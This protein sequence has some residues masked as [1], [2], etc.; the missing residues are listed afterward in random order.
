M[1]FSHIYRDTRL[2]TGQIREPNSHQLWHDEPQK[3]RQIFP[4]TVGSSVLI[5]KLGQDFVEKR[6]R[7]RVFWTPCPHT[8]SDRHE[9]WWSQRQHGARTKSWISSKSLH[10]WQKYRLYSLTQPLFL[11]SCGTR[12]WAQTSGTG[13]LFFGW[14]MAK[15]HSY[16]YIKG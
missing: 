1:V 15:M 12:P 4:F 7:G 9:N 11:V 16:M 8:Y 10:R 14:Y 3:C 5:W 2:P 13:K 6:H